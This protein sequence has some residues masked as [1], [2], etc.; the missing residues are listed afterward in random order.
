[1][2]NIFNTLFIILLFSTISFSQS[3]YGSDLSATV[4]FPTGVN[5]EFFKTG[6]GAIGGFY[7]EM[8]S[9][10]RVGLTL[11]FIYTGI[12]G[13][14]VNN[15]FQT[16]DQQQGSVDLSGNVSTI[17]ILLSFKYMLPGTSPIFYGII[18]AGL[19]VYWT[20]GNGTITYT[21]GETSPLDKS[22]FSS[23]PGFALGFGALFPAG[24]EISIDVNARYH[25]VRNSGTINV[26]YKYDNQGNLYAS[27]ESVGSSH[28]FNIGLGA[29]WNFDL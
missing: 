25:F 29:N 18:E 4:S 23:E 14:E 5:E 24:K 20:K 6:Y 7:Y 12:N 26:D 3:G 27:E 9:N 16:L 15:Y 8:E 28:F 22:E 10:W 1:M 11:G 17:P 2:K 13:E 21:G 19:Y